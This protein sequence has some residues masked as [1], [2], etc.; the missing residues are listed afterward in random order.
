MAPVL[1]RLATRSRWPPI[2]LGFQGTTVTGSLL[3]RDDV[4]VVAVCDCYQG[5]NNYVE[6]GL[7][8]LLNPQRRLLGPGYE[9]WGADLPPSHKE[10]L[11]P[12]YQTSLG[13]AGRDPAKRLV[14][15]YYSSRKN[16]SYKGCTA[17]RDF[18]ELL[19]KEKDLD[20]VYVATPDH[21]H[22]PISIAAM[23]KHK[24]VLCQ[25]PMTHSV[26]EARRW[27]KWRAR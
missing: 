19:E 7:G 25:K 16:S 17:Y 2:G 5:S 18:R 8:G 23:L 24:H 26:G 11:I 1:S 20:A 14:E 27:R 15:A 10:W 13:M 3:A 4:Q 9:K 12:G 22:A 6:W 21:W